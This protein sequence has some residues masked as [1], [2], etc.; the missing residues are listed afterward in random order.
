MAR[1]TDRE[2]NELLTRDMLGVQGG[3]RGQLALAREALRDVLR[4]ELTDR[5]RQ[6]VLMRYY[7]EQRPIDIARR[8]GVAPSTV[9]RSLQRSRCRI[10]RCMRFY[11]D[12]RRMRMGED[13]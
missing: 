10:Y 8:L 3:N 4:N 9:T 2:V 5:Q 11:F 13:D 7:E 1:R 12:Y 6:I